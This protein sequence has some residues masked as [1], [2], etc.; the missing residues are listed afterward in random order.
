[1]LMDRINL[2]IYASLKTKRQKIVFCLDTHSTAQ[3]NLVHKYIT[4]LNEVK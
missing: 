2:C 1:M 3:I 4:S